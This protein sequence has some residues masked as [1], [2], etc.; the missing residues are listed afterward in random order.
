MWQALETFYA[1]ELPGSISL[2]RYQIRL[3][4]VMRSLWFRYEISSR[5]NI[6][7]RIF[8]W[9]LKIIRCMAT[10]TTWNW[11]SSCTIWEF[12]NLGGSGWRALNFLL[13][14]AYISPCQQL[15]VKSKLCAHQKICGLW[16]LLQLEFRGPISKMSQ[17]ITHTT[18]TSS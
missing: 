14:P 13:R 3:V 5:L 18:C 7:H 16:T 12:C 10:N 2:V 6:V 15:P 9:A 11:Q 17:T 1:V 4:R 8:V